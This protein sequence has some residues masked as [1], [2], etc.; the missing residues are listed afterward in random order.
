[1]A[2]ITRIVKVTRAQMASLEAGETIAGHTYDPQHCLYMVDDGL[3]LPTESGQ[4]ALTTH[5]DGETY[6][7][8]TIDLSNYVK[9]QKKTYTNVIAASNDYAGG[10]CFFIDLMP[11]SYKRNWLIHY[12]VRCFCPANANY[13]AFYEV[14]LVGRR[15]SYGTYRI[16]GSQNDES[17][18]PMYYNTV[19]F[20]TEAGFNANMPIKIGISLQSSHS[21]TSSSY[22]RTIEVELIDYNGCDVSFADTIVHYSALD[23]TYYKSTSSNSAGNYQ[24]LV[25]YSSGTWPDNADSYTI[26]DYS[27]FNT[28]EES[29]QANS[30]VGYDLSG[31]KVPIIKAD[32]ALSGIPFDYGK[33]VGWFDTNRVANTYY[34][35]W[36][37]STFATTVARSI[38]NVFVSAFEL[39]T[40][41]VKDSIYMKCTKNGPTLTC[42]TL[43]KALPETEDGYYYMLLAK[44]YINFTNSTGNQQWTFREAK[45]IY[46]YSNGSLHILGDDVQPQVIRL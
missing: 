4:Y 15:S 43:V 22:L 7:Y 24:N 20:P 14:Y 18:R 6:E 30:V 12:K 5:D 44:P 40:I 45:P 16:R 33:M 36:N 38:P 10:S 35:G 19:H 34:A 46:Y 3:E 17:Y 25:G 31:N 29:L 21:A 9:V 26:Y 27:G 41:T 1:M 11:K 23:N 28:G 13:D 37:G 8:E 2:R 42:L 32:G 39:N